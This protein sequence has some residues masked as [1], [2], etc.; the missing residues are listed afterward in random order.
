MMQ[1]SQRDD[2]FIARFWSRVTR[3]S[4]DACWLWTAKAKY[5]FG[6]GALRVDGRSAYA[7]RV[8]FEIANGAI[9]AGKHVLHRC[10]VPGCCNPS[11]LY[12]GSDAE[13]AADRVSRGR[14][15]KGPHSA[16]TIAKIKAG[17]AAN[18]PVLSVAARAA[19]SEAMKRRWESSEWRQR[20][21]TLHGGE[22]N[23]QYGKPP[24]PGRMEAVKRAN[25]ARKGVFK[26][27]EET[28]AKMRATAIARRNRAMPMEGAA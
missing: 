2:K 9:P 13:N 5:R 4:A 17:R 10:D 24:S 15:R 11:H 27:S 8:A 7:H 25:A 1:I 21:S 22:N 14:Q 18:P 28:R 23:H 20:F 16:E 12:L 26:H 3:G 19:Q 6:Y